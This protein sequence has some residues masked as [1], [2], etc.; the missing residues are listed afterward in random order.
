MASRSPFLAAKDG[1]TRG[2]I[3]GPEPANYEVSSLNLEP[4][5]ASAEKFIEKATDI[6]GTIGE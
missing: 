2:V 1:I 6:L 4:K 3:A 5:R